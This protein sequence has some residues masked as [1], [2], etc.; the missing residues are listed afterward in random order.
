[1]NYLKKVTL[2]FLVALIAN[3]SLY[4]F[5]TDELNTSRT[6]GVS[7]IRVDGNGGTQ[8]SV[9]AIPPTVVIL[10]ALALAAICHGT[11]RKYIEMGPTDKNIEAINYEMSSID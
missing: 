5:G 4:A 11:H 10:T 8:S 6:Q 9:E 7:E 2:L 3:F 1:M